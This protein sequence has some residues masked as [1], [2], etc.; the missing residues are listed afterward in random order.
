MSNSFPWSGPVRVFGHVRGLG[1]RLLKGAVIT[2]VTWERMMVKMVYKMAYKI[3]YLLN[4]TGLV[5]GGYRLLQILSF[6][7]FFMLDHSVSPGRHLLP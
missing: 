2:R 1:G 7:N 6:I 5:R 3:L 4:P